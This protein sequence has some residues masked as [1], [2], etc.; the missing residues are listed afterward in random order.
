MSMGGSAGRVT[1]DPAAGPARMRGS[2]VAPFAGPALWV[3]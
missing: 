1:P 2:G 3:R